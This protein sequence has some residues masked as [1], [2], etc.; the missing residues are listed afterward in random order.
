[1]TT[2]PEP[3]ESP[4]PPVPTATPE[5]EPVTDD[6]PAWTY[7]AVADALA[8]EAAAEPAPETAETAE[9]AEDEDR[10]EAAPSHRR[11]RARERVR[12]ETPVE[13]RAPP[14]ATRERPKAAAAAAEPAEPPSWLPVAGLV[15][16]VWAILP[17]F[18]TPPLNTRDAVEIADHVIPGLVVMGLCVGALVVRRRPGGSGNYGFF[19]GLVIVL[20]GLWMSV[21]HLPLI[22]QATREEAPWAGTIYHSASALAMLGFSVIWMAAHWNTADF[23]DDEADLPADEPARRGGGREVSANRGPRQPSR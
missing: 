9:A 4:Q 7:A 22:A 12:V 1:V 5:P 2:A 23:P 14:R 21:T 16:S 20:A 11:R 3:A 13:R 17:R 6:E 18:L 10:Q 19:S 8:S 15:V